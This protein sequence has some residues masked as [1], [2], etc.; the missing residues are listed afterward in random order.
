MDIEISHAWLQ[1][2]DDLGIRVVS[3]FTLTTETGESALY[4]VHV[5]GCGGPQGTVAG[6]LE[7]EG[8]SLRAKYGYSW[9]NL[10]ASYRRYDRQLF[11][12]TLND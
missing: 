3:P 11:V 7:S 4:E 8:R 1:A 6:N 5:Q 12:D 10:S 9:S 2:A